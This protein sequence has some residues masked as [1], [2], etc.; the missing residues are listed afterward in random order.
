LNRTTIPL[1]SLL[2]L[3]T[4]GQAAEIRHLEVTREQQLYRIHLEARIA[5]PTRELWTAL[6]DYP[7]LHR[8]SPAIK[9]S[10]VLGTD[11]DGGQRVHTLSQVCVWIFCRDLEHVQRFR[12]PGP[13]RLEAHS[14]PELSDFSFGVSHWTLVPQPRGTRLEFSARLQPAFEVPPLLGPLLVQQGLR[15]TTLEV[16][17]GLE[18]E[19]GRRR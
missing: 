5:A 18:R 16:L 9:S 14:V 3:A 19:A 17:Q 12:S 7:N 8:L 15:N 10:Q 2:L 6:T 4:Y 13:R 1:L 11:P